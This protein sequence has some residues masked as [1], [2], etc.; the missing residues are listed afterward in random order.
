MGVHQELAGRSLGKV[1]TEQ[2]SFS[3]HRALRFR[4]NPENGPCKL[5]S[6]V[7]S[8]ASSAPTVAQ[9]RWEFLDALRGVAALLV[10]L[11]H[12][13][14]TLQPGL[15]ARAPLNLGE[16][17]VVLFFLLSG[18]VI[19]PSIKRHRSL[20]SFWIRRVFRLYP[21]YWAS[22]A[23]CLLLVAAALFPPP[24]GAMSHPAAGALLNLTMVQS[25]FGV[26]GAI[27][28]YWTL[29]LELAFYVGCS[30]LFVMRLLRRPVLCVLAGTAALLVAELAA[31]ARHASLPAGRVGLLLSALFGA[32]ALRWIAGELPARTLA[33]LALLLGGVVAL[34]LWLR[35]DRFPV[36]HEV[37][38]PSA[39]AVV[40]SWL[41]AYLLFFAAAALR[42][43]EM[44]PALLWLGRISYSVYLWHLPMLVALERLARP[45]NLPWWMT[46]ALGLLATLLTAQLSYVFVERPGMRLGARLAGAP[47]PR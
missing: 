9:G 40:P 32:V 11:Q 10:A 1:E 7:A 15:A 41:L 16:T 8:P 25:L 24:F 23:G 30:A 38:A 2:H 45:L 6:T 13:V 18:V 28:A 36:A 26:P 5:E 34:G 22:L 43:R 27:G 17:G 19:P 35:F 44:P 14:E 33:T 46:L 47:Q 37:A 20:R 31:A 42:G 12:G 4:P 39:A 21:A 29:P 3:L